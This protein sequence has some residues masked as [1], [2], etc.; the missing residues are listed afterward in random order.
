M[1]SNKLRARLTGQRTFMVGRTTFSERIGV[2]ELSVS[3]LRMNELSQ[4][5]EL[6]RLVKRIFAEGTRM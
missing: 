4:V 2:N 5:N 6:S 1:S 3:E